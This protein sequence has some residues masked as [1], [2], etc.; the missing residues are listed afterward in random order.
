MAVPE[1]FTSGLGT[2][3]GVQARPV[4]NI[5]TIVINDMH[6]TQTNLAPQ[7]TGEVLLTIDSSVYIVRFQFTDES[8]DQR[9]LQGLPKKRNPNI[10]E[11]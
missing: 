6:I 9:T 2:I 5:T 4:A 11:R 7:R 8:L 1:A 3:L 10:T